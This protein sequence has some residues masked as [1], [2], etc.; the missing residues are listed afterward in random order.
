M[1]EERIYKLIISV[2]RNGFMQAAHYGRADRRTM[3]RDA[4][5]IVDRTRQ[6]ALNKSR[7]TRKQKAHEPKFVGFSAISW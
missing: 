1:G 6:D 3:D 4:S 7:I 5:V 2:L